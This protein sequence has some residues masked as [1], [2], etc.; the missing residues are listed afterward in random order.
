MIGALKPL[1]AW[2]VAL[3]A[4]AAGGAAYGW[5]GGVLVA[6]GLV[7]WLLWQFNRVVRVMKRSADAP[8]G[9]VASAVMF[10]ARLARGMTLIEIVRLAGSLGRKVADAPETWAWHDAGEARVVLVMA[11]AKLDHWELVRPSEAAG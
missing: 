9:F 8:V 7:F 2:A 4:V 3:A 11:G 6:S 1:L 10:N 5:R